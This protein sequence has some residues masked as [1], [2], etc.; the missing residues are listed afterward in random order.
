MEKRFVFKR[1]S[2]FLGD[3][4]AALLMLIATV[5]LIYALEWSALKLAA[6]LRGAW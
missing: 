2:V 3:V 1:I 5:W 4:A 6:L